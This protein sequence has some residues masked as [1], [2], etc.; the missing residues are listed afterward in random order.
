NQGDAEEH[1]AAEEQGNDNTAAEEPVTA[2]DDVTDQSIQSPTPLT[3]PPQQPQDI[4]STSQVQSPPPQQQ[5]PPPAQPQDEGNKLMNKKETEE[6][7]VNPDDEQVEG[8]Q[9]NIYHIDMDHAIKV[10]SMQEDEPEIQETVEV[11]TTAK[12]ITEVVV[13]VSETVSVVDVVQDDVLA[14]PVNAAAVVTT[15]PPVKVAVPSTRRKRGVVIRDP[16]EDS[17]TKTPT[18][19]KSKDKGKAIMV[20]EPKPIK[21][22]QQVEL[23]EAYARKLQEELNQEIDSEVAMDHV[24]QKAKENP[25]V[26]RYQAKFNA[27]MEFLVKSKEQMEEEESRAIALINKTP[28]QKVAKR[29]RLNEEA[30]DVEELKQH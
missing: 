19:T 8:R 16:E 27:N 6:F 12:L 15:A 4:P 23:D 14:T 26:Q 2:V 7:R 3:P 24:K 21:K 22:K 25:Y 1:G 30:K 18:K 10:L 20:E 29:R 9:A 5:S 13:V 28:A 17:S 11:V